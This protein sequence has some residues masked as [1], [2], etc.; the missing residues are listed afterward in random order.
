VG[1][2]EVDVGAARVRFEFWKMPSQALISAVIRDAPHQLEFEHGERLVMRAVDV[3]GDP[4]A[5][6]RAVLE[7]LAAAADN[8][9]EGSSQVQAG[10]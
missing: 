2:E 3:G 1:I 8:E 7:S 5:A 10:R 6:A 4:L 9:G